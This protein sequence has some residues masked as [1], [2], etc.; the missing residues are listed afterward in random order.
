MGTKPWFVSH[1]V[2]DPL[3]EAVGKLYYFPLL[4]PE[5]L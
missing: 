3:S 5:W 1:S 2:Q 4:S